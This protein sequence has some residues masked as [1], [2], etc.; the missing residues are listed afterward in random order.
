MTGFIIA[1]AVFITAACAVLNH[2]FNAECKRDNA[3]R[4]YWRAK[5]RYYSNKQGRA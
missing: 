5:Q 4:A 1:A 2:R 3:M